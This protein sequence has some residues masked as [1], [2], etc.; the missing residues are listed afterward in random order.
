MLRRRTEDDGPGVAELGH[1]MISVAGGHSRPPMT[2]SPAARARSGRGGTIG[3]AYSA[4]S[5]SLQALSVTASAALRS[6]RGGRRGPTRSIGAVVEV[7]VA[8]CLQPSKHCVDLGL[9][10]D[11]G[12]ERLLLRLGDPL[13]QPWAHLRIRID[14]LDEPINASSAGLSSEEVDRNQPPERLT[15]RP[16]YGCA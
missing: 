6:I 2:L 8:E 16:L 7:I 14:D 15:S 9:L 3:G 1:G 10:G 11:E 12:G 13:L 5:P 4:C